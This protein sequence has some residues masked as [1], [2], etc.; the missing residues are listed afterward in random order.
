MC[1]R[2]GNGGGDYY[3]MMVTISG[4]VATT[5]SLCVSS[6]QIAARGSHKG[7]ACRCLTLLNRANKILLIVQTMCANK[8]L[9]TKATSN[10]SS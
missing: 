1:V 10:L 4:V 2:E 6:V 5:V 8:R 7:M 3:L 9:H